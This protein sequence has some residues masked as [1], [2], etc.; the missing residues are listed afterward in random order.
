MNA[1]FDAAT[2]PS[3][4]ASIDV[5]VSRGIAK[6]VLTNPELI[7]TFDRLFMF[8]VHCVLFRL[9]VYVFAR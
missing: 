8:M 3:R 9:H 1:K 6:E 5:W 2:N 7:A 4:A